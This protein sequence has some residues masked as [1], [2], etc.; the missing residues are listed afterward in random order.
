LA[1]L[2][3]DLQFARAVWRGGPFNVLVQVTNRCN[4]TCSFCAFWPNGAP[5]EQ[6]L[7]VRDYERLSEQL[8]RHGAMLISV[9]GGE[10]TLRTDLP[11]I[12]R[13]LSRHHLTALFTNGWKMTPALA[14]SLWA[15]G[16]THC[17]V[18]IDYAEPQQHDA[19]RGVTGATQRAWQAVATLRD[20]SPRGGRNVHVMTIL[21][22]DNV[23][24]IE[25]L[26]EQ[27][28]ELGVGHQLTLL[29]TDGDRRGPSPKYLP[30]EG[31]GEKM[32]SLWRRYR[33]LRFLS[34]YFGKLDD[35][36]AGRP[37]PVC[38]AGIAGFNVDHLGNVSP[39][40]E[41]IDEPAGN[42][43]EHSLAEL[44]PKL[45]RPE[46]ETCQ[47]CFTACRGFQQALSSPT[48]STW[49]DLALRTRA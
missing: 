42:L 8:A 46:L 37:M 11:D 22:H 4:M 16:L 27:T 15:A 28:A 17:S 30:P 32:V 29:A 48:L 41:R 47:R 13:V 3:R 21:M 14:S 6:E 31:T 26:L 49:R 19:A 36:L 24:Q 9:E 34:E 43:R 45:R 10:P 2:S 23:D 44:L 35:F 5:P 7:T 39:C 33:H 18:S 40:I 38:R 20:T 1:D 12:V 25:R